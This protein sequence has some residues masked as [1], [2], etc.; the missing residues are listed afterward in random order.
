MCVVKA[1]LS[2][3]SLQTIKIPKAYLLSL[4][5]RTHTFLH[6]DNKPF[7]YKPLFTFTLKL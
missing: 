2:V 5:T 1:G 7:S 6:T 4:N 3:H